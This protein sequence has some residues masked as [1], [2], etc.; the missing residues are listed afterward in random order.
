LLQSFIDEGY[1]DETRVITNEALLIPEGL[2]SPELPDCK[3]ASRERLFS[4]SISY[5]LPNG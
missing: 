2:R 4:D 5:Y 3:L 1:W